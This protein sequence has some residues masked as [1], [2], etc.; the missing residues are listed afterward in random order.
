VRR[1]SEHDEPDLYWAI[2]GGGGNFGVVTSFEYRLHP[3]NPTVVAG[4]VDFPAGQ[5]KDAIE[6]YVGL[7]TRAPR[8]LSV[9][10]SLAANADGTPGAQIYVVYSGQASSGAKVLEPLQ[11][12]GKPT[13]N[14][15]GQQK[16]LVVQTQFDTAPLNP[17][18][19]YLKGGF[20]R[21]YSSGLIKFLAEDFRPDGATS[22]YFQNANGAV[23]DIAQT[24]TAFSHRNAVA[25]MML[26]GSWKDSSQDDPG[27]KAIH[28][29]WS[30]LE[31]FTDGYYVNLHD[32][33][34]RDK[35]TER[36]YGPNFTRLAA[37]KRRFDPTNLFRLNANIKPA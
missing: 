2:R 6:F 4:H 22:M 23:A 3:L 14:T 36:N 24:A 10:L 19:E 12:F 9:D 32:T 11:R 37:L 16:Y 8:E 1:V 34:T 15:I 33:D 30:K 18:H 28:A 31:P 35:G 7:I 17:M 20:V 29:T 27:R 25:N 13:Q 21:D 5:V 26:A